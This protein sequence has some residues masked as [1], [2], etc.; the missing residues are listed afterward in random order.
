M[1]QILPAPHP[2]SKP[3]SEP[4]II[5]GVAM[6]LPRSGPGTGVTPTT[7]GSAVWIE[8]EL[9]AALIRLAT[10]YLLHNRLSAHAP[11]A[12][13]CYVDC[14]ILSAA[15]R[16]VAAT[17]LRFDQLFS[18]KQ[19]GFGEAGALVTTTTHLACSEVSRQY[20][21]AAPE[22]NAVGHVAVCRTNRPMTGQGSFY[23]EFEIVSGSATIGVSKQVREQCL[24][25]TARLLCGVRSESG[26]A[27][28]VGLGG[29][30]AGIAWEG[31][32]GFRQGDTMGILF[33]CGPWWGDG[34]SRTSTMS[35]QDSLIVHESSSHIRIFNHLAG[36]T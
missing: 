5:I 21:G 32:E 7:E 1:A 34:T 20:H 13:L 17:P 35:Y 12:Q 2:E 9:D 30:G 3:E 14:D 19:Y 27:A 26:L 8:C 25:T 36:V 24:A 10:S 18:A 33:S 31:H 11:V 4:D 22:Y 23:A 16:R 29:A 15:T 28:G 6:A